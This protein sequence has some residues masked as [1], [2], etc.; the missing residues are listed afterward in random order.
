MTNQPSVCTDPD[1]RSEILSGMAPRRE[2]ALERLV[3]GAFGYLLQALAGYAANRK[4]NCPDDKIRETCADAYVAFKKSTGKPGFSFQH[5]DACGYFFQ[6][7]RNILS[8]RLDF[9]A[10]K[11]EEFDPQRHGKTSSDTPQSKMEQEERHRLLREAMKKLNPEERTILTLYADDYKVAEIARAMQDR[12]EEVAA[13]MRAAGLEPTPRDLWTEPYTKVRL[14]R[15]RI[16]LRDLLDPL[17]D[18]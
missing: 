9:G 17:L 13:A 6:I 7:A 5:E 12:Y 18:A 15:A 1:I 4:W 8:Q 14:Q 16:K 2:A 10:A 11:N 3:R